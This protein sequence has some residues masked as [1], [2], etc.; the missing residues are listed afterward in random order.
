MGSLILSLHHKILTQL[1]TTSSSTVSSSSAP[2]FCY[3]IIFSHLSTPSQDHER[4]TAFKYNKVTKHQWWIWVGLRAA[5]LS[6]PYVNK[7]LTPPIPRPRMIPGFTTEL[8]LDRFLLY[9]YEYPACFYV[10]VTDILI[11]E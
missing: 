10:I 5:R 3:A 6:K 7:L 2:Q 11:I 8:H 9:L 1:Y 4:L